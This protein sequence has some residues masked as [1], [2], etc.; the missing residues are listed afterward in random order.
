MTPQ[1]G[2]AKTAST[3]PKMW[4][5]RSGV[6]RWENGQEED[7]SMDHRLV[8]APARPLSGRKLKAAARSS[9]FPK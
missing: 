3:Q 2:S 5:N 7:L 9:H 1:R 6:G 8:F 4:G